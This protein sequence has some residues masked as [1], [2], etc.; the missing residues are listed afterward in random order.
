M[1]PQPL[2]N[3]HRYLPDQWKCGQIAG[4]ITDILFNDPEYRLTFDKVM[5]ILDRISRSLHTPIPPITGDTFPKQVDW[6]TGIK[7]LYN[8]QHRLQQLDTNGTFLQLQNK[9]AM[10]CGIMLT[11]ND[12]DVTSRGNKL[13]KAILPHK[14]RGCRKEWIDKCKSY[15]NAFIEDH[16]K[17]L[18]NTYDNIVRES[19]FSAIFTCII[20]IPFYNLR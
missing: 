18:C 12:G 3:D 13:L 14:D 8:M 2:A 1:E 17:P 11:N 7:A 9:Q 10:T 6:G 4:V 5:W 19:M 20:S 16:T 15:L